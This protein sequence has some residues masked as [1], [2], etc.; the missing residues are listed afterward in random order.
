MSTKR[1]MSA[2]IVVA[3]MTESATTMVTVPDIPAGR[4]VHRGSTMV[5]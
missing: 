4:R 3:I 5:A 2:I 1:S